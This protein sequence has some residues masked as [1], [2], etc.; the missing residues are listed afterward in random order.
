MA[1]GRFFVEDSTNGS[2]KDQSRSESTRRLPRKLTADD[3]FR[4]SASAHKLRSENPEEFFRRYPYM[5]FRNR[6]PG[7]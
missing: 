4:M 6:K 1:A 2:N 7:K 3:V 5:D